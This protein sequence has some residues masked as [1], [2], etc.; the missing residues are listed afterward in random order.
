MKRTTRRQTL[1]PI[2]SNN[3]GNR[4]QVGSAVEKKNRPP[5]GRAS[6]I[7]RVGRENGI[8]PSTPSRPIPKQVVGSGRRS[9]VGFDRRQSLGLA[10]QPSRADP[11]PV[12]DKG[13]QLICVK[14]LLKFLLERGYEYPVSQKSLTR[15]SGKDF[16]NI[17]TF[18]LRHV[19][20][21]FQ[22]GTMKIEDEIA[23]NFRAMGYP[24][25]MSKTALV[26]AGSPHTWPTLLAAL[27]WLLE[28]IL[29]LD[30][31]QDPTSSSQ[32]F[33]SLEELESKTDKA[34][35]QYLRSAY[36]AFLCGDEKTTEDLEL[37]LAER[38]E[39]DDEIIAGEIETVTDKNSMILEQIR[40]LSPGENELDDLQKKKAGY[41]TDL[42]QFHDLIDQMDK[43]V[44]S[45]HKKHKETQEELVGGNRK[46][47]SINSELKVL[48]RSVE[49]QE[50]LPEDVLRMQNEMKGI[51]EARERIRERT[52]C[53]QT[54][55]VKNETDAGLLSTTLSTMISKYSTNADDLS[56]HNDRPNEN[57]QGEIKMEA[58]VQNSMA[59]NQMLMAGETFL[60]NERASLKKRFDECKATFQQSLDNLERSS[61]CFSGALQ[62]LRI[63]ESK[64]EKCEETLGAERQASE[65]KLRLRLRDAESLED[66]VASLR[67]PMALEEQMAHYER[68]CAELEALKIT[69]EQ[70]NS[71]RVQDVLNELNQAMVAIEE[72]E[73]HCQS[74]AESMKQRHLN[75]LKQS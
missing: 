36:T 9:S 21:N 22:D 31:A 27:S 63:I 57:S 38:F 43:H 69:D 18:L 19:D 1:G 62:K 67:D 16:T 58:L 37:T 23:M 49:D 74:I 65:A 73:Q 4:Q 14:K 7:P 20:P 2:S 52:T 53:H 75:A 39:S 28:R 5:K 46:L 66:V 29:L 11:R 41:T 8:P 44:K 61:E 24:F 15:P 12:S 47:E 17:M 3:G 33:K 26:A 50:L 25:P 10:S 6:M 68:Q 64:V 56:S 72:F 34:F 55:L 32:A 60:K 59:C 70:E 48:A 54:E 30:S 40:N 35:F 42:E 71:R 13:F 51:A 45:L